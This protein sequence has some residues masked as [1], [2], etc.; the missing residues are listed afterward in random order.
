MAS[1]FNNLHRL[2]HDVSQKSFK[3][4]P[5]QDQYPNHPTNE[6]LRYMNNNDLVAFDIDSSI[7]ISVDG[8]TLPEVVQIKAETKKIVNGTSSRTLKLMNEINFLDLEITE[9]QGMMQK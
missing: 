5:P 3:N 9:L 8:S 6:P 4:P 7:S 1:E 2:C